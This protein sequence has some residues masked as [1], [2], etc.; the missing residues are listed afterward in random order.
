MSGTEERE[1]G[2]E[3]GQEVENK[4]VNKEREGREGVREERGVRR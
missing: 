3:R 1:E 4:R 2:R